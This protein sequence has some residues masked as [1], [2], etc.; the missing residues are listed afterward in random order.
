MSSEY[1][2]EQ[3]LEQIRK[4]RAFERGECEAL[5]A[6][7][8]DLWWHPEYFER[9]GDEYR[10]S[11]AGWSGNEDLIGALGDNFIFWSRCWQS[12]RRGGHYV[13]VLPKQKDAP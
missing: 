10:I 6:F 8:H 3:D 5:L 13:F 9:D 4:W 2:S 11:T 12:H 1:P 7:V